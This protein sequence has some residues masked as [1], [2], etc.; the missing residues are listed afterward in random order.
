M[1]DPRGGAVGPGFR[2]GRRYAK[3]PAA[4]L[5][6]GLV[7][8]KRLSQFLLQL[9]CPLPHLTPAASFFV[10]TA[11]ASRPRT[12]CG[13]CPQSSVLSD[14]GVTPKSRTG[15]L[16]GNTEA[17]RGSRLACAPVLLTHLQRLV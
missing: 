11:V 4:T 8:D 10:F 2:L 12:N 9:V 1:A 16:S 13:S 17:R 14:D 6:T 7:R 15:C 3:P 5:L